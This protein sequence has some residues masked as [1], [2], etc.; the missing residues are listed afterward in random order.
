MIQRSGIGKKLN[1]IVSYL[2]VKAM[3]P[4]KGSTETLNLQ[5]ILP[6]FLK[7][8]YNRLMIKEVITCTPFNGRMML[9]ICMQRKTCVYHCFLWSTGKRVFIFL[10]FLPSE[11]SYLPSYMWVWEEREKKKANHFPERN[12]REIPNSE[13]KNSLDISI[14]SNVRQR[15][16]PCKA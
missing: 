15:N 1:N 6:K 5:L 4:P 10:R 13:V 16:V 14:I 8:E 11:M 7:L 9:N 12:T 3:S 2:L